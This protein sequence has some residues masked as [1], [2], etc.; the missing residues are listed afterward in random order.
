MIKI[1]NV[2]NYNPNSI[3]LEKNTISIIN[4]NCIAHG[5]AWTGL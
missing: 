3:F 4:H 2:L 1:N 5:I